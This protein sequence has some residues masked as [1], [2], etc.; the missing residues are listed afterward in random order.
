MPSMLH[1]PNDDVVQGG[2][3]LW[4]LPALHLTRILAQD[5]IAPMV[6]TILDAPF[7]TRNLPQ[8]FR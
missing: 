3:H 1:D 5:H 4:G 7:R 8:V 6:Q 2:Q